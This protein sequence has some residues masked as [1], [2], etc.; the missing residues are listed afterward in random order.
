M[1]LQGA[2]PGHRERDL[3]LVGE[4][5]GRHLAVVMVKLLH[6]R[7]VQAVVHVD[8]AA[9]GGKDEL[10]LPAVERHVRD[11]RIHDLRE[12]PDQLASVRVPHLR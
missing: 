10:P 5:D 3:V 7:A 4:G 2:V 12:L 1:D 11:V 9:L 6:Q 8:V